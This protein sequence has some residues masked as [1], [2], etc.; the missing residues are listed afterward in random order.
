M[1]HNP[2][3]CRARLRARCKCPPNT[4]GS[5]C[6]HPPKPKHQ[7]QEKGNTRKGSRPRKRRGKKREQEQNNDDSNGVKETRGKIKDETELDKNSLGSV[8]TWN[9]LWG[10]NGFRH[11]RTLQ[12]ESASK[13]GTQESDASE[14]Q[15]RGSKRKR[16]VAASIRGKRSC[17]M[18]QKRQS[19]R[20]QIVSVVKGDAVSEISLASLKQSIQEAPSNFQESITEPP[21]GCPPEQ[22]SDD[23]DGLREITETLCRMWN[24]AAISVVWSC[25]PENGPGRA[26]IRR[27]LARRGLSW[28]P[29]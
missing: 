15:A 17:I 5:I 27:E 3:I 2:C 26:F 8:E 12:K 4:P 25:L 20:Q 16:S 14:D 29:F 9:E 22:P 10:T 28:H 6:W 7:T 19:S 11:F 24:C 13:S 1:P 18:P 23:L 21:L